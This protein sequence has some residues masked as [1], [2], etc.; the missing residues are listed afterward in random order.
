MSFKSNPFGAAQETICVIQ[1]LLCC[2]LL[3]LPIKYLKLKQNWLKSKKLKKSMNWWLVTFCLWQYFLLQLC[4]IGRRE[5]CIKMLCFIV[6]AQG[7]RCRENAVKPFATKVVLRQTTT[8]TSWHLLPPLGTSWNQL[9]PV[10]FWPSFG[11]SWISKLPLIPLT[12]S[13]H[14]LTPLVTC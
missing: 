4:Q 8:S 1:L 2:Q 13:C 10:H 6:T 9:L 3:L 5:L 7:H 14:V 11:T 12:T